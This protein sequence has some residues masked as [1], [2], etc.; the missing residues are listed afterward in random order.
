MVVWRYF[1]KVLLNQ[2][3]N[4]GGVCRTAPATPGLLKSRKTN[5]WWHWQVFFPVSQLWYSHL[6][7]EVSSATF[8]LYSLLSFLLFILLFILQPSSPFLQAQSVWYHLPYLCKLFIFPR[9]DGV[10]ILVKDP[11]LANLTPMQHPPICQTLLLVANIFEPGLPLI[12]KFPSG[13]NQKT[14]FSR[15]FDLNPLTLG[16]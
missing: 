3:L 8:K 1:H 14:P 12:A 11:P 10:T 4:Y 7:F 6:F 15:C 9:I 16:W 13:Q 5:P 2:R